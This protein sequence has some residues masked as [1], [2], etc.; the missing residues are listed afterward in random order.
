M[1]DKGDIMRLGRRDLRFIHGAGVYIFAKR[2]V[3][4]RAHPIVVGESENIG[5]DARVGGGDFAMAEQDGVE[6]AIVVL[7]KDPE[8]RR[9]LTEA[10]AKALLRK[11]GS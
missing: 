7:E 4:G 8:A 6:E 5:R 11:R 2:G 9:R 10:V 1:A 3:G